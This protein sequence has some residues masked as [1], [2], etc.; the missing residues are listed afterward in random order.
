MCLLYFEPVRVHLE[1]PVL[2]LEE[3]VQQRA[4]ADL[5]ASAEGLHKTSEFHAPV[6]HALEC[7][8]GLLF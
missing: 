8:F 5:L 6:R 7:V 4:R 1:V 2:D 3:L